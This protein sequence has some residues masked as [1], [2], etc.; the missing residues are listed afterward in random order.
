VLPLHKSKLSAPHSFELSHGLSCV[1]LIISSRAFFRRKLR[2]KGAGE[3]KN[4][5]RLVQSGGGGE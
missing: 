1:T 4:G 2:C 3:L 5:V